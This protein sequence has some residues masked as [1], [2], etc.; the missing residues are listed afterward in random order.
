MCRWQIIKRYSQETGHVFIPHASCTPGIFRAQVGM[1]ILS[2]SLCIL[3]DPRVLVGPFDR[4][5]NSF[6]PPC[7]TLTFY[8]LWKDPSISSVMGPLV[9]SVYPLISP[10]VPSYIL[11][12]E[13]SSPWKTSPSRP[14]S[15]PHSL[16]SSDI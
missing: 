14:G 8:S 10:V 1:L 5:I 3:G 13:V 12:P 7:L 9:F 15:F 4:K 11:L 16:L 6:Q 2:L